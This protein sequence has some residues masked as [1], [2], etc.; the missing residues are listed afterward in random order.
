MKF[1]LHLISKL[2]ALQHWLVCSIFLI[3]SLKHNRLVSLAKWWTIQNFVAWL[4]SFIFDK[5]WK[6]P[7][8]DLSYCPTWICKKSGDDIFTERELR[9]ITLKSGR[10]KFVGKMDTGR[11]DIKS[12]RLFNCNFLLLT[13]AGFFWERCKPPK[14]G[15]A[16]HVRA[17][18]VPEMWF[19]Q[20][21]RRII[22]FC[23]QFF[24]GINFCVRRFMEYY[25]ILTQNK[26]Q[27]L[28]KTN[29]KS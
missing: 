9:K 14:W 23:D 26:N 12:R 22:Q 29:R 1:Y 27:C 4:R 21:I 2:D 15:P 5:T 24:K 17:V 18:F 13:A 6:G 8:R 25:G 19:S 20:R 11:S 16:L 7:R 10:L 3:E 28:G